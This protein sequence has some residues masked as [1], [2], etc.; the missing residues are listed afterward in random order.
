MK[1]QPTEL[2]TRG[3]GARDATTLETAS[4]VPD[5]TEL[6]GRGGDAT[7]LDGRGSAQDVTHL[8]GPGEAATTLEGALVVP[9]Q[10]LRRNLPTPLAAEYELVRMLSDA[11]AQADVFLARRTRDGV[12]VALKLYRNANLAI[13]DHEAQLLADTDPGHVVPTE[14]GQWGEEKWEVQEYMP[15]GTLAE[16]PQTLGSRPDEATMREIAREL[17][18]AVAHIHARD[19][20]HR[21][22]K[23]SNILVRSLDPLDLVL[24]D[25]GLAR[26]LVAGSQ[27]GSISRTQGYAAPEVLEGVQSF[28]NDWWSLGITLLEL[29]TGHHPFSDPSG[30]RWTEARVYSHLTSREVDVSGVVD[31]RLRLLLAGLLTKDR[32][33]RWSTGQTREWLAGG[34]PKVYKPVD[35][36]VPKGWKFAGFLSRTFTS[37]AE[38]GRA[39]A[40]NWSAAASY[41][42]GRGSVALRNSLGSTELKDSV[43][44]VFDRRDRGLLREDGLLFELIS[45]LDPDSPPSYRGRRLDVAGLAGAATEATAGNVDS[46]GWIRSLRDERILHLTHAYATYDQLATIDEKLSLW[47]DDVDSCRADIL[48]AQQ[49]YGAESR[50]AGAEVTLVDLVQVLDESRPLFEGTML[51]CALGDEQIVRVHR[52]VPEIDT[53][54]RHADWI[55]PVATRAATVAEPNPALDLMVTALAAPAAMDYASVFGARNAREQE[56]L[57][58]RHRDE[59]A[60]RRRQARDGVYPKLG[61]GLL[62]LVAVGIGFVLAIQDYP[63]ID[64]DTFLSPL[65]VVGIGMAVALGIG[66][67][68]DLL[69]GRPTRW[70]LAI[71]ATVGFSVGWP[72]VTD[73]GGGYAMP[74]IGAAIGYVV[75]AAATR[76]APALSDTDGANGPVPTSVGT[77][78]GLLSLI[79]LLGVPLAVAQM[80]MSMS[81][82][83]ATNMAS[84]AVELQATAWPWLSTLLGWF[85]AVSRI[86]PKAA[87]MWAIPC[88]IAYFVVTTWRG[89]GEQG[90]DPYSLVDAMLLTIAVLGL[91]VAVIHQWTIA[92]LVVLLLVVLGMTIAGGLFIASLLSS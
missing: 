85:D 65:K 41:L 91:I 77:R 87:V 47:W 33:H 63:V 20:A 66:Y 74:M 60:A 22:I 10:F 59:A 84:S 70:L 79:G 80:A 18:E 11:G 27:L 53:T 17:I 40:E 68:S 28:D 54:A 58:Q 29:A 67:V 13:D 6:E 26:N 49:R 16:F 39:F 76:F 2:E 73:M 81:A 78:L 5:A 38:L 1:D 4:R 86:E 8:E 23:P 9:T 12:E 37:P 57:R 82:L 15:L 88:L 90:R 71:G 46:A 36:T 14:F 89:T 64:L 30:Q 24:A 72:A 56:L 55:G 32:T 43:A 44:D 7:E 50:A 69:L 45:V 61:A 35:P 3:G 31:E 21:D 92:L 19:L 52:Q 48:I 25:F 34:A 75:A 62:Y 83:A 51:A 42:A